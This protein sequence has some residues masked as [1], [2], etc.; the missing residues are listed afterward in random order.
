MFL[1]SKERIVP[2]IILHVFPGSLIPAHCSADAITDDSQQVLHIGVTDLQLK[3][4]YLR[5]AAALHGEA[6]IL[7]LSWNNFINNNSNFING[8]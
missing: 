6:Y 5:A 7:T 1:S 8:S 2:R 4:C 3:H